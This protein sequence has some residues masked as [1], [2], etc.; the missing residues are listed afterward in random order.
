MTSRAELGVVGAELFTGDDPDALLVE[1]WEDQEGTVESRVCR[2]EI[3]SEPDDLG[4]VY[5]LHTGESRDIDD[6]SDVT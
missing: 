3:S 6:E 5:W 4:C 2:S 1:S